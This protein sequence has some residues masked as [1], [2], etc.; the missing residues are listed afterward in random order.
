[1]RHG[2]PLPRPVSGALW[3]AA[4][5]PGLIAYNLP[6]SPTLFNQAAALGLWGIA[7]AALAPAHAASLHTAMA[8][9]Q[10]LQLALLPMAIAAILSSAL[11]SLPWALG[12]SAAGLIA[13]TMALA[14][15]G[16]S[17]RPT[18]TLLVA[19]FSAWLGAGLLNSAIALIQVFAPQWADGDWIARSAIPG[20]AVG[21]M[22]QPN[23][24]ATLLLW[25]C[26]LYT[27]PSP[28]D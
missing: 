10:A 14:L 23:H 7:I 16:A 15:G 11:G 13:A 22:R 1:M 27:S 6:P 12:L 17:L 24:L 20:R 2:S 28:R 19:F 5:L 26:L 3:A 21:N 9:T 18:P 25:S 4:L 8:R